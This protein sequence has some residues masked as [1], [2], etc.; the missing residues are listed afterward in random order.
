ML[1]VVRCES[2]GELVSGPA[3]AL[4]WVQLTPCAFIYWR[5]KWLINLLR[6]A[7]HQG[8]PSFLSPTRARLGRGSFP[9][10]TVSVDGGKN[11]TAGG[12]AEVGTTTWIESP[13]LIW[14]A[15]ARKMLKT[16]VISTFYYQ[17]SIFIHCHVKW[18]IYDASCQERHK[19]GASFSLYE[20]IQCFIKKC[21]HLD[22]A[23]NSVNF[24]R[25][26]LGVQP[27]ERQ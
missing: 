20:Y 14:G 21:I 1:S 8:T 15:F 2:V 16:D 17:F 19:F 18:S 9:P 25:K 12:V 10:L 24:Y 23:N 26:C 6:F 22:I 13:E 11:E 27:L 5:R 7:S 3:A 4:C